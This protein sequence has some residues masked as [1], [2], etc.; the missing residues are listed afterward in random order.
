MSEI[1]S[2]VSN[3]LDIWTAATERKNGT[4]RGGGKRVNL[5]GIEQ[6]RA[7]ILDLA[8]RGK[9]VP[10]DA[11][12]EPAALL[13]ERIKAG[14]IAVGGSRR[15]RAS[16]SG[17][18]GREVEGN[19]SV[20]MGW[21]AVPLSAVA[22]IIRGVTYGKSDARD[23]AQLGLIPLLRGHNIQSEINLDKLVYVPAGK[24]SGDQILR[25]GDIV[26]AMS[27]GSADLVGKS[28]QY[29][30]DLEA[31]FGAFCGVIRPLLDSIRT[32]LAFFCQTPFYR[33]Q[34]HKG[35]RGIGIQNLSKGDLEKLTCLVPPESEQ[36][37][38]VA[39][40]SEL[41]ALCDALEEEST[42]A[43]AAHQTLVETLL[44]TLANSADTADL[45]ANWVRLETHFDT[46]FTTEASV[47]ALKRV[48]LDLAV[49]GKL[50]EQNSDDESALELIDRL[51]EQLGNRPI[52]RARGG[53]PKKPFV[54]EALGFELPDGWAEP[55]LGDVGETFIG[56][57]YSPKDV[58][59]AGIP[60]LRSS[61]VQNGEIDLT[62]LVR[63][64][65][66]IKQKLF[67]EI[68]DLLICV[69]NGSRSLVGKCA[70]I[71]ELSEPTTFGAFMA[72][73]RS[74]INKFVKIYIESP[75]FRRRLLGVETTTINQ[76]TQAN[77]KATAIPLPPLAEQHRIVSKVEALMA[78]CHELRAGITDAGRIQMRLADAIVERAAS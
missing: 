16:Q 22:T 78:I 7:L 64:R 15:K 33:K 11:N 37:R 77:L 20:P 61:N 47:D 72:I 24:I 34:A 54:P 69:R 66:E 57:T 68:G 36:R 12:D 27:S 28:A 63:V 17:A 6:L 49:R 9:L 21:Q 73:Y 65:S 1:V 40:V 60:V 4:G 53:H 2:L 41:M 71:E 55:T 30:F 56:L 10:Q 38:I 67:V 44:A 48:I 42:A 46:L 32:Y 35:G 43:L 19:I 5:Y 14:A 75:T 39:K 26:V 51:G 31:S 23:E 70:L 74:P 25:P 45:A 52:G 62:D 58:S 8:V 50:V 3:H 59:E 18:N 29:Q 76:I 13:L